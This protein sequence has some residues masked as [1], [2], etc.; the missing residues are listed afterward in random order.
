[1]AGNRRERYEFSKTAMRRVP[2]SGTGF[3]LD[4][5]SGPRTMPPATKSELSPSSGLYDRSGSF[6]ELGGCRTIGGVVP[7]MAYGLGGVDGLVECETMTL[8]N[9]RSISNCWV[10][11]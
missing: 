9:A 2:V 4:G 10:S 1:M 6:G 3:T 8:C 11:I 7:A 5:G